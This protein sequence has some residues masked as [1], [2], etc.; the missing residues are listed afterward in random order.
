MDS[1]TR[2]E[3]RDADDVAGGS[4]HRPGPQLG[5]GMQR[6]MTA[7]EFH[8]VRRETIRLA[9]L[10]LAETEYRAGHRLPRHAHEQPFFSL[11]VRGSFLEHHDLGNRECVSTSLVFYPEHEGHEEAFGPRGGRAFHVELGPAWVERMQA[12]GT[13]WRS[14]SSETLKGR[15]NLLM[16]K[17]YAWFLSGG[18]DVSAEEIVL[19]LLDEVAP[20]KGVGRE[21]TAPEWLQCIVDLLHDRYC[22]SVRVTDLAELAGVHPVHAARV[23]RRHLGCTIGEYIR[24]LRIERARMALADEDRPLSAIAFATGFSD[25]AHFTRRFKESI[26]LPPG[27]YRR[28]VSGN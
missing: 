8:G 17:L 5:A 13:T 25:Q 7:G 14:G 12:E 4:D 27:E 24:T 15:R 10:T 11:L 9:G 1:V 16:A 20:T 18:P 3:R 21:S 19:E 23:F 26:G 6:T 22:E 28:L 2:A